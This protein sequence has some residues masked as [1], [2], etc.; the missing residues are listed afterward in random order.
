MMSDA[1]RSLIHYQRASLVQRRCQLLSDLNK[2]EGFV[3]VRST[4]GA[5]DDL[6]FARRVVTLPIPACVRPQQGLSRSDPSR[7]KNGVGEKTVSPPS[8]THFLH[9]P[10]PITQHPY[11]LYFSSLRHLPLY[12]KR[13]ESKKG[14]SAR[15]WW[16]IISKFGGIS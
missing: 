2:G 11:F 7:P 6:T 14:S 9:F 3:N 15:D 5:G 13:Q 1:A 4:R 8:H 12:P 10:C 16:P